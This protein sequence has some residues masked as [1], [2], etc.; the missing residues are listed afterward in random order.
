MRRARFA[1]RRAAIRDR[2]S[3]SGPTWCRSSR[4]SRVGCFLFGFRHAARQFVLARSFR[5]EFSFSGN[6]LRRALRTYRSFLVGPQFPSST[7]SSMPPGPGRAEHVSSP[8]L[9]TEVRASVASKLGSR[10]DWP[11]RYRVYHLGLLYTC[12][13]LV[14]SLAVL[15]AYR[16]FPGVFGVFFGVWIKSVCV[17]VCVCVCVSSIN[18]LILFEKKGER[19]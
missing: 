15:R 14:F 10:C 11:E 9:P 7:V 12:M 18:C 8:S 6:L 3:P 1:A 19:K 5:F 2:P 13:S 4:S 16:L 17:C